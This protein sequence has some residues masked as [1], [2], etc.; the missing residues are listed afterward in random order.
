[1]H[2]NHAVQYLKKYI[3]WCVEHRVRVR[4]GWYDGA[5]IKIMAL[6]RG[7]EA[8]EIV[9][10]WLEAD[11]AKYEATR[12]QESGSGVLSYTFSYAP[13]VGWG[14]YEVATSVGR[15]TV[16][17]SDSNSVWVTMPDS[18]GTIVPPSTEAEGSVDN[19]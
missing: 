17:G 3:D 14:E 19:A 15:F 18:H 13:S 10:K 12:S 8:Q 11:K 7:D 16:S 2:R 6:P 9:D 4:R 5:L 1:M